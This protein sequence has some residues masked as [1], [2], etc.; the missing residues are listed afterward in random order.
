MPW[1]ESS[2]VEE[3]LRFVVLA[4]RKDR[5]FQDL[6][7]EFGVSRQTGYVWLG[8]YAEQGIQGLADRSRRPH[9]SPRRTPEDIEQ[10][11]VELRLKWPDWGAPKLAQLLSKQSPAVTLPARTVHRILERRGLIQAEDRHP[12]ASQ[13]F[14][15]CEP[16]E[17]WQ[18]DFK[19]PQGFNKGS[20]VGPLS[21]LDDHSRYVLV[22]RHLGSTQ[23][24]GVRQ[25][26][27]GA[28][29]EY[30]LPDRLLIDHGTPWWNA[31]SPWG[32]TELSVWI[33]R[34]G[35]RLTYSGI[36]HPQTQGKVERMHGVLQRAIRKRK[37]NPEDQA[38]LDEFRHE[39]N[40]VRPHEALALATPSSRWR[41]SPRLLPAELRDW[42]YAAGMETAQLGC[43][44]QLR[45]RGR[46]WEISNALRRKVVGIQVLDSRAVVYFCRTPMRELDLATGATTWILGKPIR[47]FDPEL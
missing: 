19:G 34:V 7:G 11:V 22:L 40:N 32:L 39:Y 16:N 10:R 33:M 30:G 29:R 17:L 1:R 12:Q 46:R 26:L 28:F 24:A 35:V 45:W 5:S 18:M 8:R 31:R 2:V 14:E 27:E 4:S 41:P 20:P 13:R 42:E 21:V 47:S 3:R 23:M 25:S 9:W 44:G 36:C 6:C 38:W 15:R 43:D 37:A